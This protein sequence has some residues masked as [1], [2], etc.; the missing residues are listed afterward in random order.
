MWETTAWKLAVGKKN[1]EI[2]VKSNKCRL[3]LQEIGG[4]IPRDVAKCQRVMR[5]AEVRTSVIPAESI[6]RKVNYETQQIEEFLWMVLRHGL[7]FIT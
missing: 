1:T 3:A 2:S 4:D 6:R 5:G 7:D